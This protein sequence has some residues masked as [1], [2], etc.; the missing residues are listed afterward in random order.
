MILID[1][2]STQNFL[3]CAITKNFRLHICLEE[4][5]KV[6]VANGNQLLSEGKRMGIKVDIQGFSFTFDLFV[7]ELASCE[8]VLRVQRLK[9][10][11]PSHGILNNL[12][13]SFVK[14]SS[15][16]EWYQPNY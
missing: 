4:K 15:C 8:M 16:K 9:S 2:N 3:D 13:C 14:T 6:R 12:P 5:V 1:S 10:W 11:A 7:L